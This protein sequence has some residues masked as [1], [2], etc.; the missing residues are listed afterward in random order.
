MIRFATSADLDAIARL[1]AVMHSESSFSSM[2]YDKEIVKK[3]FG[4]LIESKQFV[5][6]SELDGCIVGGMAAVC[7]QSWFGSDMV[8]NDLA[9]FIHPEHRGGMVSVRLIK[10]FVQWAELA[11]AKQI[12]PGVTTGDGR[13]EKLYEKLGFAKCGASFVK[14]GV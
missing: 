12:R 10:T 7:I 1:G 6:V 4:D 11:G 2:H 13:A 14:E 8:A 9:L 3:T 5:V